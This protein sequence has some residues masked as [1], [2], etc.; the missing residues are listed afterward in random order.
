MKDEKLAHSSRS[1]YFFRPDQWRR[2][3]ATATA[4]RLFD[5]KRS[6]DRSAKAV[7][8]PISQTRPRTATWPREAQ[9]GLVAM[10]LVTI[11]R[12]CVPTTNRITGTKKTSASTTTR[13]RLRAC[14]ESARAVA[15]ASCSGRTKP[16][17]SPLTS[18]VMRVGAIDG[19]MRP[20]VRVQ[21]HVRAHAVCSSAS[22]GMTGQAS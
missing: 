2:D 8:L 15:V 12:C 1:S 22:A 18:A 4:P 14:G 6:A 17:T 9:Y 13:R 16:R 5:Y 10:S 19:F 21:P 3:P 20:S 7:L 11:D